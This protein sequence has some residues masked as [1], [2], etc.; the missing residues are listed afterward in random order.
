MTKENL[1]QHLKKFVVDQNYERYTPIDQAVWRFIMRQLKFF[2]SKNA[3]PC[4]EEGLKKTGISINKIPRISEMSE[5]LSE[6]GWSAIPVSG[7]IPPAAF[8][9]LQ[10]L[11]VLPIA[12]DMRTLDH[13]AYTP[14]PD[15]IHEAAGHAPILIDPAF[16]K[17]LKSYA[18]IA[19]KS[20]LNKEDI[21][22][23]EAIRNLS[24]IKEHPDSTKEDIQKCEIELEE[25]VK[26][27]G[28]PSEGA[29]TCSYEL[30]DSRIRFNWK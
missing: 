25:A 23:Y 19:A 5:K 1:P 15:I 28:E 18:Q 9:E 12:S 27:L 29:K 10:S 17:Y 4:Y 30:V 21:K 2:L 16:S 13:L 24:D 26:D 20:I 3:H 7:F 8:M 14:A 6:F 22:V 11:G